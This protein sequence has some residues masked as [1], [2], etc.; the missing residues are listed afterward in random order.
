MKVVLIGDSIRMGYQ[1]FV[2]R[3][4]DGHAEVWGP[5]ANCRHSLWALD[6]FPTWVAEQ[7]PDVVHV[8]FGIHDAVVMPDGGFQVCLQQYRLCLQRFIDKVAELDG[9]T[10]I[11]AT[12]TPRFTPTDGVAMSDWPKMLEIDTYNAIA[13]ELV[14][15][16][17]LAVNDLHQTILGNDFTQC[18]SADGCHMTERGNEVLS[19]AVT[20]AVCEDIALALN[21]PFVTISLYDEQRDEYVPMSDYGLPARARQLRRP[22]P[23]AAIAQYIEQDDPVFVIPDPEAL[24][25]LPNAALYA[26]LRI[27]SQ[28]SVRLERE[29]QTVGLLR[30]LLENGQQFDMDDLELIRGMADQATLAIGNARAFAAAYR[31]AARMEALREID[32]AITASMDLRLTLEVILAQITVQLDVDAATV[33]L[34]D[35]HNLTLEYTAGRGFR[36]DAL[37]HTRLRLGEGYAGRAALERQVVHIPDLR[38]GDPGFTRSQHFADEGFVMYVGAPLLAKGQVKGVLEVFCR[39][40]RDVAAEWLNFLQ[41][42]ATQAAIAVDNATLFDGLQRSNVELTLA[43]DTTLEGWARALELRDYETQGHSRRV[44]EMTLRLARAMGAG[45]AELVHVRRGA[46][47][48]DIGKMGIPDSIL[49]KP[50]PL[51]DQEWVSMRQHPVYARNLLTPIAY[52]RP[53]LDIP[54]YHHEKWDGT[55]YPQGL[56]GEQIPLAAR[57]FAIVDVW[58]AL[59][60]DRPYRAAWPEEQVRAYIREQA[61]EHFDPQV[62]AAFLELEMEGTRDESTKQ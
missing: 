58:D 23:R 28:A 30:L 25:D 15:K 22:V 17:G 33:L 46:L 45:A 29:A 26:A 8:N 24:A 1:P 52:L 37:Q 48:H 57:I 3:K 53:A 31:R 11:W 60:S 39:T 20:Q 50:G 18:L 21:V 41:D 55:G 59:R 62:V 7:T 6:H 43:Y 9:T 12:T 10:M 36:T 16:A 34:F 47:L 13:L 44:T 40:P 4:L 14:T 54:Y 5:G 2:A 42:L 56:K 35:P 61:G 49:H 38:A 19:D 32:L 51:T 27:R